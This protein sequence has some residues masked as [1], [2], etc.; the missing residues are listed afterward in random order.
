MEEGRKEEIE[1]GREGG[2][3]EGGKEGLPIYL[4]FSW[5]LTNQ[6]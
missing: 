2:K 4:K 6:L 1:G 3:K 5:R